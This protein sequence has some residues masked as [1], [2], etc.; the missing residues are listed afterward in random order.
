MAARRRRVGE[1]AAH[2]IWVNERPAIFPP[3]AC[4]CPMRRSRNVGMGLRPA[5]A[6]E[7]WWG[8]RGTLWVRRPTLDLASGWQAEAPAPGDWPF[9]PRIWRGKVLA[10]GTAC[11]T[12]SCRLPA[13]VGHAS[14]CQASEA[15]PGR[16]KRLPHQG[17]RTG[18]VWGGF[19]TL[20]GWAFRPRNFMK[21]GGVGGVPSGSA[22]QLLIWPA[23]GR[24]KR[25]PL[26]IGLSRR[27]SGAARFSQ[28]EPPAPPSRAVC[29]HGW[30]MLQLCFSLPA[31]RK[32]GLHPDGISILL[33]W[34]FGPR[35]F[36]KN[37]AS[38]LT[39][40]R[41]ARTLACRVGPRADARCSER[42]ASS[43]TRRCTH[44]CVRH[45][46]GF[47]PLSERPLQ[48]RRYHEQCG[49]NNPIWRAAS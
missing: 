20:L 7:K 12:K 18:R 14:A 5:K 17:H 46:D 21:N 44:E 32:A 3:T 38:T 23:V 49:G 24:R 27:E 29:L 6:D 45:E 10:G 47:S 19:S 36:M 8:R 34:A 30:G 35:N 9:P 26:E 39:G 48:G 40:R 1:M 22:C 28:A 43:E 16:R 13:W 31:G 15:R 37:R 41:G 2:S 25:L 4:K 11:A 42:R 33:G